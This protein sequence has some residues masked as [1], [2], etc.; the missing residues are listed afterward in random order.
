MMGTGLNVIDLA[1]Q[2]L[3]WL[4]RRQGVLAQ[5]L[6][7]ANTPGYAPRDLLPFDAALSRAAPM[8]RSDPRH[9]AMSGAGQDASVRRDR[10][11]TE[12]APNGNAVSL[13]AQAL[14]VAETDQA[15]ALAAALHR[16]WTAMFRLTLGNRAG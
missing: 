2:R 4:E 6:A 9:I 15:H 13:D 11:A 1:E 8:V 3:R 7:H 14:K 16:R 10:T 12:R 5:N